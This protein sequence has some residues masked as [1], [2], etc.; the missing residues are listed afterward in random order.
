VAKEEARQGREREVGPVMS[1]AKLPT[2]EM[3]GWEEGASAAGVK[4]L[5]P[6]GG[7]PGRP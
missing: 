7:P 5:R 4:A 2:Q 6:T 3:M 1:A